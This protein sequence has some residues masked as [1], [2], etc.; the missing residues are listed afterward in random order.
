MAASFT[1]PPRVGRR[2]A[3]Y[4]AAGAALSL[5]ITAYEAAHPPAVTVGKVHHVRHGLVSEVS[6]TFKSRSATRQCPVVHAVARDTN[7][8]AIRE[9]AAHPAAAGAVL[10]A[11][12]P[13]TY[14]A[15]VSLSARDYREKLKTFTMYVYQQRSCPPGQ[16][17]R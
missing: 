16:P 12:H 1:G 4:C 14:V 6:A 15:S 8:K 7:Q 13:V 10:S 3:L 9:V 11:G 17:S 2:L 5:G